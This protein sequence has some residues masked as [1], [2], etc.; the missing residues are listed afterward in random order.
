MFQ[1]SANQPIVSQHSILV[2]T[3]PPTFLAPPPLLTTTT[4]SPS[5]NTQTA[6]TF[7]TINDNL[8][9]VAEALFKSNSVH[10][11]PST[12]FVCS[13]CHRTIK[14]C[15]ISIQ[16]SLHDNTND[17]ES[18]RLRLVSFTSSDDGRNDDD[19]GWL[20][21]DSAHSHVTSQDYPVNNTTQSFQN[22]RSDKLSTY[23]IPETHHI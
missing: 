9:L 19:S 16:T 8:R 4:I 7:S 10:R 1:T 17:K 13:N 20:S 5:N 23:S 6:C 22:K 15:D 14:R 18:S 12:Q 2:P 3:F 11:S 21:F